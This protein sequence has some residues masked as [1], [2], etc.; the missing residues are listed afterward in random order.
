MFQQGL[1]SSKEGQGGTTEN[2]S[3]EVK[4]VASIANLTGEELLPEEA[5]KES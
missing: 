4:T 1:K 3:D 5:S 2:S